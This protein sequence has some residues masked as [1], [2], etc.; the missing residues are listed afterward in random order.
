MRLGS[1]ICKISPQ[2]KAAK[3][4]GANEI[5]ER[6]RHRFEFNNKYRELFTSKGAIFSGIWEKGDLVEIFELPDHIWFVGVQFHPEFQS[7]PTK[8]H[9]LFRDFIKHAIEK[10]KE[11]RKIKS[12]KTHKS[13]EI[14]AG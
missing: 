1:Y 5:N 11:T 9:P 3:A 2:T 13:A 10:R 8:P 6:H 14:T 7:K 12:A 4:Y